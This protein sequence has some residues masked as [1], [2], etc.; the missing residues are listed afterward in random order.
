MCTPLSMEKIMDAVET[1][2]R[3]EQFNV[4]PQDDQCTTQN[5]V[6]LL[7]KN[8]EAVISICQNLKNFRP[9]PRDQKLFHCL[10]N[11]VDDINNET[12][13]L[14]KREQSM[15]SS[16]REVGGQSS[17]QLLATATIPGDQVGKRKLRKDIVKNAFSR[18]D[19]ETLYELLGRVLCEVVV[20]TIL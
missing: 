2:L 6:S 19:I 17:D 1:Y 14:R 18:L 15:S 16:V 5:I 8:L 3:E 7:T 9:T 12:V 4:I 20:F 11:V 13:K 10:V